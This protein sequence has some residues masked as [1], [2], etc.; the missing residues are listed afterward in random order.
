MY[1]TSSKII[2]YETYWFWKQKKLQEASLVDRVG[3]LICLQ[4]S[5]LCLGISEGGG[6]LY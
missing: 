2:S 1:F 5:S 3:D 6:V 4:A